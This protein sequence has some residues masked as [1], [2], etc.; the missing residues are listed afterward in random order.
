MAL[1]QNDER[2]RVARA[3]LHSAIGPQYAPDYAPDQAEQVLRFLKKLLNDSEN[4]A[5]HCT[6]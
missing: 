3:Y 1:T 4:F 5:E 6:W 2:L